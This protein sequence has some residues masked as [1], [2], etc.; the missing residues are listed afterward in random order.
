[1]KLETSVDQL[2]MVGPTYAKRLAKLGILTVEDLLFHFP[3]RYNDYSLVSDIS[4]VQPGEIVTIRAQ[5]KNIKNEFTKNGKRIQRAIVDDKTKEMEIIWF[6]QMFLTRAIKVGETYN[7]SGKADWFGHKIVMV[8]PEYEKIK[9]TIDDGKLKIVV[10]NR[11]LRIEKNNLSSNF[12]PQPPS[13][14]LYN[15]SSTIHTGRLVPVYPETY[16][17]SSKWLRSRI[18]PLL[19][20]CATELFE[21]LPYSIIKNNDLIGYKEAIE[22]IHFPNN[23]KLAD[24]ARERLSFDELFLIQLASL[25][26]KLQW[27]KET[28]GHRFNIKNCKLK[29]ENFI[30]GL[31]FKLTM[32]QNRVVS[33]ILDDL[34]GN[35]PMNRLLE[36]DVG[37]GKTVVAAISIY[38]AYLNGFQ[39]VIMAPT[40]ILANQHYQTLKSLFEPLGLK[41]GLITAQNRATP[42]NGAPGLDIFIGTH[43]LLNESKLYQK[44]GLVVIDEQHRF[45]VQQRT[46]LKEKGLNPH[47][48]MMTATPIPR[49]IALTLFAELDLSYLDEMPL[50]RQRIK[51]WVIPKEKRMAAYLW[52]KKQIKNKA[53]QAFIICPLIEESETLT[54][55]KAVTK[56][57]E[58]LAQ[59]IFPDLRLGLLHGRLKAKE[60]DNVLNRFRKGEIDLLVATP[61][62]EVGL[63][64]PNATIMMI[65]AADRFGLAQL[66]QLRGRVGRS[67][68]Q[69]YCLL[70][71]EI[72]DL[73]RL[74]AL[75]TIYVGQK[76]AELDLSLRGPGEL[77][78]TRQHGLPDLRLASLAD[79][80]L[81]KKTSQAAHQI[82]NS[83]SQFRLLKEKLKKYKMIL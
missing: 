17:V 32:A 20:E 61:V 48:L 8:A 45:G 25:Q 13:S 36:G 70:F 57:Y 31:P 82:L 78:G 43:A 67:D 34:G 22:Q 27:S 14:I 40:E 9:E 44:V 80:A 71:S 55:V 35:Q 10:E 52:I 77:Y 19:K 66:H 75:E 15:P 21:Y 83:L 3:H 69:S 73:K 62:V 7:F 56:E 39:S 47:L 64:I 81:I 26:K 41:I 12:H 38:A 6:N 46:K 42:C 53:P 63:D 58:K 30:A 50:G 18:A 79:S 54:S 23:Q 16:G 33:E 59:Q 11:E 49:S 1:M 4:R 60:K 68:Q 5:I 74:K 28:V 65:E 51:T 24:Q 2:Y 72:P 29:I 37:S 76:L